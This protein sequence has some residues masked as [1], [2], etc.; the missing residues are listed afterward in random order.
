MFSCKFCELFKNRFF[1]RKPPVA[2]CMTI[3]LLLMKTSS[4]PKGDSSY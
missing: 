2:A 1:Y 4:E 3:T